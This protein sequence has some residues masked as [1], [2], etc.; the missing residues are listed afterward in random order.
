MAY[1]TLTFKDVAIHPGTSKNR[2]KKL[3]AKN[4][5]VSTYLI[6]QLGK[7]KSIPDNPINL[8]EI[9]SDVFVVIKKAQ[10]LI[11]GRVVILECE[12]NERLI[13]LYEKQNFQTL[14]ILNDPE[15]EHQLVTMFTCIV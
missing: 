6:G 3:K 9:L 10:D 8:E 12:N 4:N 5:A 15:E 14:A 2:L 11:G 1:F 7:N 13:K